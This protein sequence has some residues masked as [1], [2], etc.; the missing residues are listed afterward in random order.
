MRGDHGAARVSDRRARHAV[1]LPRD[2]TA[3]QLGALVVE[4]P[5]ELDV[6]FA[7]VVVVE[8]AEGEA[9]IQ[10]HTAIGDVECGERDRI[11]FGEGLA[12]RN[13]ERSVLRQVVAG[14]RVARHRR[15]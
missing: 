12:Q 5:A 3:V 14:V 9:V 7:W 2:L 4:P 8:A 1:P 6:H 15:W 10:Q 13:I 11:F